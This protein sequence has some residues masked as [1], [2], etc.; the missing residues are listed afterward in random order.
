MKIHLGHVGGALLAGLVMGAALTAQAQ[1]SSSSFLGPASLVVNGTRFGGTFAPLEDASD[2][3]VPISQLASAMGFDY[4]WANNTLTV[5]T[6]GYQPPSSTAS[7]PLQ[8]N[9]T[10]KASSA[11]TA[12]NPKQLTSIG[13]V[14]RFQLGFQ[15]EGKGTRIRTQKVTFHVSGLPTA[16]VSVW[17]R[18][19]SGWASLPLAPDGSVTL[20]PGLF[21]NYFSHGIATFGVE[22][23][24]AGTVQVTITDSSDLTVQPVVFTAAFSY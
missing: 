24:Q 12:L 7:G 17:T 3:Y 2:L 22:S 9:L 21:N 8:F 20:S 6:A 16:D 19:P 18:G 23:S 10:A 14:A 1:T 4:S 5:T 15:Y 11:L 13:Q